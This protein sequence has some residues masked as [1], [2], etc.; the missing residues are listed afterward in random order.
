MNNVLRTVVAKLTE[1]ARDPKNQQKIREFAAKVQ[2]KVQE[3]LRKRN[4]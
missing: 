1:I 2:P 4:K 3:L